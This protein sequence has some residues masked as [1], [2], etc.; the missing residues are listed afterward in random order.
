MLE[1]LVARK[2]LTTPQPM[3]IGREEQSYLGDSL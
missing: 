2:L 3:L 1:S